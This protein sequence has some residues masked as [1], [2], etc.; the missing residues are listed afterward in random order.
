MPERLTLRRLNRATLPRQLLLQREP[1]DVVQAIHEVVALQ[2]Q[3]PVSP[4]VAMRNRVAGFNPTDLNAAFDQR[5]VVKASLM[6]ITLHAV[7]AADHR[8]FHTAMVRRLRASCLDDPRFTRAGLSVSDVDA[9][10]P[11]V[12]AFASQPRTT[13]EL[14]DELAARCGPLPQSSVWWAMRRF[15][16][17][18]HAPTGGPWGFGARP[19]YVAAPACANTD[20]GASVQWLVRRYLEGF[21]PA[22]VPD[23]AQFTLLQR[24]AVRGALHHLGDDVQRH[25]GSDGTELFDVPGRVLPDEHVAARP[26]L[27]GM[28][29]STL[30]AYADR[31]RVLPPDLRA[32]VIRR[33]G[34]V[35]P[36]LLLDGFVAGVWRPARGGIEVTAYGAL[37]EKLWRQIEAEASGLREL[38]KPD[39][40]AY[41]RYAHWWTKLPPGETR[42]MAS[43]H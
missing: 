23:I 2:A 6:R 26:R 14:E 34:D 29:D 24:S 5:A 3:E 21:G 32:H 19:S 22:S 43:D 18:V 13:A 28:W 15:L 41:R 31:S 12:L 39:P 20:H 36:A 35:L 4:H 8:R 7:T 42:V 30:L 9:V 38:L 25:Q 16:P 33:N 27:L 37:N 1:V 40:G 17:V 11:S 10:A